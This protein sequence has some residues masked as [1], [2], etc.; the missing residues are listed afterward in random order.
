M[1]MYIVF[2]NFLTY[3]YGHKA[4]ELEQTNGSLIPVAN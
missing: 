2:V 3:I 4:S 1:Y